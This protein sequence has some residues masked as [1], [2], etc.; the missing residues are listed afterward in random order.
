MSHTPLHVIKIS[1]DS[2][3]RGLQHGRLLKDSIERAVQFYHSFFSRHIGLDLQSVRKRAAQFIEPTHRVS[4]LLMAEFEGI[5]EGSGQTLEDI[6][7]LSA[8][9]EITFESVAL[10]ECSNLFVGPRR[11]KDGHTL[12]G[13]SWDWRPEV[14]DFR[15]V[16][17][18]HCTDVPDHVMISECGQ[19]GKY[20][21]N[22]NGLGVVAA[23]LS[24][25]SKASIGD[26]L[27]VV[28]ARKMLACTL[29]SE[30]RQI[31]DQF[32]IRATASFF[33][34][35]AGGNGMVFEAAPG[36]ILRQEFRLDEICWHTNHCRLSDEPC[37]FENSRIR[38]RRWA[39]LTGS[40][41]VAQ[42]ST[43]QSWL[44]DQLNAPDSICKI[45]DDREAGSATWL[46]TIS[47]IVMDLNERKM[48]VSDGPSSV[49]P[50]QAIGLDS[51]V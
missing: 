9:Y 16:F 14:L 8:R 28:L 30:A 32:P 37:S 1:G 31:M 12:L 45:A 15:V 33:L 43:V 44:A 48:W 10:G 17:I 5:A 20:G 22:E 27:C 29:F 2:R 25:T 36:A 4:P 23:G 51:A 35:D 50:F 13:Q 7:S 6:F 18:A 3:E 19:P 34:A 11:E 42:P 46:Q 24:C 41:D 21:L 38:G 39:E 47:S 40:N 49:N 26:N